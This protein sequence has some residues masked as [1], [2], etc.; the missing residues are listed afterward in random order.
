ML[1][2]VVGRHVSG[3]VVHDVA[4]GCSRFCAAELPGQEIGERTMILTFYEVL[5][6]ALP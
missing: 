5:E 1:A 3:H 6:G 4:I 2:W